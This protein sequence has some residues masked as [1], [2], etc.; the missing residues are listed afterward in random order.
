MKVNLKGA[1]E[2]Q[3]PLT[4]FGLYDLPVV[5]V[6]VPERQFQVP[7]FLEFL[8]ISNEF[9]EDREL[10]LGLEEGIGVPVSCLEFSTEFLRSESC[11]RAELLAGGSVG[12]VE[13]VPITLY[14]A[15]FALG[16]QDF[17][18]GEVGEEPTEFGGSLGV[19]VD[20]V[21]A[22]FTHVL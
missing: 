12:R 17:A 15:E 13:V 5:D 11:G 1:Q 10:D 19:D 16:G 3:N 21:D 20:V 6:V 18:V 9:L 7:E 8:R 14:G 2:L 22:V 4:L